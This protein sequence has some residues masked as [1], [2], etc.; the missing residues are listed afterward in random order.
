MEQYDQLV[1]EQFY[2]VQ[3]K[4]DKTME[5]FIVN[6]FTLY[7][8]NGEGELSFHNFALFIGDLLYISVLMKRRYTFKI[9][10]HMN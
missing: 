6:I 7:D 2:S 3:E 10:N 9:I 8:M 4:I 5:D 1:L